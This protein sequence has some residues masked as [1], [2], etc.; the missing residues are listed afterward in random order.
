MHRAFRL[1]TL[2]IFCLSLMSCGTAG[3]AANLLMAPFKLAARTL[4]S[5]TGSGGSASVDNPDSSV[6]SVAQRGKAIEGCGDYTTPV[7]SGE[8]ALAQR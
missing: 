2:A 7:L 4:G 1:A 3:S 5:L 8:A 6:K